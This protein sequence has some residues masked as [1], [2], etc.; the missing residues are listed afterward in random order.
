MTQ[1]EINNLMP[2]F[3]NYDPT[4]WVD[5]SDMTDKEKEQNPHYEATGGY[6]KTFSYKEMCQT[7]WSKDSDWNKLKFFHLPNFDLDIFFEIT[8]IDAKADYERLVVNKD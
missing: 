2:S 1:S 7:G 8:G 4:A 6:L 3:W 5:A